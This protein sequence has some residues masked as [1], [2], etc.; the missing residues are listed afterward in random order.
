MLPSASGL[1]PIIACP[2]PGPPPAGPLLSPSSLI[3]SKQLL[4]TTTK[5]PI[6]KWP[7]S[8]SISSCTK[9]PNHEVQSTAITSCCFLPCSP[10]LS[11]SICS[12]NALQIA[13]QNFSGYTWAALARPFTNLTCLWSPVHL[14]S[15]IAWAMY[16]E[17][18][19][20]LVGFFTGAI[21]SSSSPC[22]PSAQKSKSTTNDST[23]FI[24]M[25][26]TRVSQLV[27]DLGCSNT[28]YL[29]ANACLIASLTAKLRW[30]IPSTILASARSMLIL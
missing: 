13:R 3:C 11:A 16:L 12:A 7:F 18:V 24:N 27:A 21:P 25:L 8:M 15:L 29:P 28:K 19:T 1:H 4:P 23:I 2:L 20:I 30:R 17:L 10:L 5:V 9:G 26:S 6:L 14:A 22:I